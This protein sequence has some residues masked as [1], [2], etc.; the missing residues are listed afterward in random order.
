MFK[1]IAIA[2]CLLA[3]PAL[4]QGAGMGPDNG[5]DPQS[6]SA[7]SIAAAKGHK[8]TIMSGHSGMSHATM[9]RIKRERQQAP[10]NPP[11]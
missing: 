4:A 1:S 10:S 3:P 2:W 7:A 8:R 11:N 6:M 9:E 5:A